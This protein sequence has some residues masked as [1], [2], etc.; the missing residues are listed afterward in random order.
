M[1]T[2]LNKK[3]EGFTIIEVLIVL[4]IAGLIMLIVFLA[5]PALQRN[6]HNTSIKNDVSGIMGGVSEFVNNNNGKV[7][8]AI[9]SSTRTQ[10][11]IEFALGTAAAP[12]G[13]KTSINIGYVDG[14]SSSSTGT[15]T[16]LAL[17][18]AGSS[19]TVATTDPAGTVRVVTHAICDAATSGK[20]NYD[21][22][23]ARN[24]VA[25]YVLEGG[26]IQCQAT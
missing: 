9:A 19:S 3:T 22:S 1:F 23:T 11:S 20:A 5:V 4:A 18:A 8:T 12:T 26:A 14:G 6:A 16:L 15:V 24:V 13:N 21:G 25:L 17:T 10:T 7:P 2:K